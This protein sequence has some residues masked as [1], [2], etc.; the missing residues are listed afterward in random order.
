M[1]T[2]LRGLLM[3]GIGRRVRPLAGTGR[4]DRRMVAG[5]IGR[6]VLRTVGTGRRGGRDPREAID[7]FGRVRR[8]TVRAI[9]RF[10]RAFQSRADSGATSGL[11]G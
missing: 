1:A 2:G 11:S 5:E 3:G 4:P 9:D 10:D 6:R 7:R 8:V